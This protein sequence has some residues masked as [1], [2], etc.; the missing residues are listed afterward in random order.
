MSGTGKWDRK[1]YSPKVKKYIQSHASA[2]KTI[3]E[4]TA[5]I[6][7]D[8]GTKYMYSQ[9]KGYLTRNKMPF[10]PNRR[11]NILITDEQA[12]YLASII[13]GRSSEET[14]KM[15]NEKYGLSLTL[16]QIRTWKKNHKTPSG[17]DTRWRKGHKSWNKGRKGAGVINSGCFAE[18]HKS[19]N[20]VPIGTI[21]RRIGRDKREWLWIKV[22][23]SE[24]ANN[25]FELLHRYVWE[26]AHGE[27]PD[28]HVVIFLDGNHENCELSNLRLVSKGIHLIA[29]KKFGYSED[30]QITEAVIRASELIHSCSAAERSIREKSNVLRKGSN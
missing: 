2:D 3:N 13:P 12:E 18:G 17:Y 19:F 16:E 29:N 20:E 23:D 11:H 9:I 28:T 21:T 27:I 1:V 6:N 4:L 26:Q 30:P 7:R 25:N 14:R 5:D 24:D 22:R 15:I 10:K 8:C